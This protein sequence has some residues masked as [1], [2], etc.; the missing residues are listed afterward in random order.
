MNDDSVKMAVD[1]PHRVVAMCERDSRFFIATEQR[2]YELVDG[3][4]MPMVIA[5]KKES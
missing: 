2:V 4:W 5:V 1:F 3:V